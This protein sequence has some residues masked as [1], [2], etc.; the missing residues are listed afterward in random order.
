M[1]GMTAPLI[2]P[3]KDIMLMHN[4]YDLQRYGCRW[5]VGSVCCVCLGIDARN[6]NNSV[7]HL[8]VYEL[9]GE[10]GGQP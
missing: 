9:K 4:V 5:L 1:R 6:Q 2:T 8:Q 10:V 3:A 7:Q